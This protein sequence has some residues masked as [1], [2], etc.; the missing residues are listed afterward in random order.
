MNLSG[1]AKVV[2]NSKTTHYFVLSQKEEGESRFKGLHGIN[3][4]S[5]GF[6]VIRNTYI[7]QIVKGNM[8][9]HK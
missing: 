8:D 4:Q 2:K 6:V 7:C 3:Y 5:W 1:L 9:Q